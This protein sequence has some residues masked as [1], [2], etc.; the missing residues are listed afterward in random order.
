MVAVPN[1]EEPKEEEPGARS[2]SPYPP[3]VLTTKAHW[4]RRQRLTWEP[5]LS[6]YRWLGGPLQLSRSLLEHRF[7]GGV[8]EEGEGVYVEWAPVEAAWERYK[9]GYGIKEPLPGG[10]KQNAK[11]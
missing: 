10:G 4:L 9:A 5:T 8:F 2:T 1:T 3:H 7:I 11:R 6:A